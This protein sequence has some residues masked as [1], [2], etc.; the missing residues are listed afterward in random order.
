MY[1]PISCKIPQTLDPRV[2][3]FR[4][5]F[6]EQTHDSIGNAEEGEHMLEGSRKA[7]SKEL[8]KCMNP[9]PPHA[10]RHRVSRGQSSQTWTR[11]GV[12]G[13][14]EEIMML[15]KKLPMQGYE[16][17]PLFVGQDLGRLRFIG[18]YLDAFFFNHHQSSINALDL[19]H[20]LL[21]RNFPSFGLAEYPPSLIDGRFWSRRW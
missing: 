8:Q 14:E 15:V 18:V 13:A 20:Q 19:G 17:L 10:G 21:R 6:I 2:L 9:M 3:E 11:K 5:G 7:A 1:E 16:C 12:L 4:N